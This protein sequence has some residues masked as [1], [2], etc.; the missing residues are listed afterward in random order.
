MTSRMDRLRSSGHWFAIA[1]VFVATCW[2]ST[3]R[4]MGF[5][6][7]P[8]EYN[9]L[10]Q[11]RT[12]LHGRLLNPAILLRE[13]FYF[14]DTVS[15]SAGTYSK[16]PP[17][18]SLLVTLA[19]SVKGYPLVNPLLATLLTWLT[20]RLAVAIAS[21]TIALVA[22][23]LLGSSSFLLIH[24]A[25]GFG[26]V[27][28][29]VCTVHALWMAIEYARHGRRATA[30]AFAFSWAVLFTVRPLNAV[31]LAV[32]LVPFLVLD[33]LR[34]P[35]R[36]GRA[37]E[38]HFWPTIMVGASGPL[39]FLLYNYGTTGNAF[40]FGYNAF[41][42]WDTVRF[43]LPSWSVLQG[44]ATEYG[45]TAIPLAF[46]AMAALY[47]TY[48]RGNG[49]PVGRT[50]VWSLVTVVVT[51]WGVQAV[52]EAPSAI[53]YGPRYVF[54]SH[55]L[56]CILLAAAL[57]DILEP[58]HPAAVAIVTSTLAIVQL[59]AVTSHVRELS[60]TIYQASRI[61]S[62]RQSLARALSPERGLVV[63]TDRAGSLSVNEAAR[64]DP[65]M[66]S[67]PVL[68]GHTRNG[69]PP[70]A[71]PDVGDRRK[72]VWDSAGG[73]PFLWTYDVTAKLQALWVRDGTFEAVGRGPEEG[74]L[75][76]KGSGR[77]GLVRRVLPG[78][79]PRRD[80]LAEFGPCAGDEWQIASWDGRRAL[81]HHPEKSAIVLRTFVAT[82]GFSPAIFRFSADALECEVR[83]HGKVAFSSDVGRGCDVRLQLPYGT[84]AVAVSLFSRNT[85]T[86]IESSLSRGFHAFTQIPD[87]DDVPKDFPTYDEEG[88]AA[89]EPGVF[90]P[91]RASAPR[92]R[93]DVFSYYRDSATV[94][95]DGV[96][97][98]D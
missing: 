53:H 41:D 32:S 88:E 8:E 27:L 92:R 59:N 47:L 48:V 14:T 83:V 44:F 28:S 61:E 18:F 96:G 19:E 42:Q 49:G 51:L 11:G 25:T 65:E 6:L 63:V 57:V 35:T 82:R 45:A 86:N 67:Q 16:F 29:A 64:N 13:E 76:A 98:A 93:I 80:D 7:S 84:S 37:W 2:L 43:G 17:G 90:G 97:S 68:L 30:L 54:E 58:K 24:G 60:R 94:P 77:C 9:L 73:V 50:H 74:W 12:F 5:A 79:R 81:L 62:A 69:L 33:A 36:L 66:R 89:M 95:D 71:M 15:S 56:L 70:W 10:Y 22:S 52:R 55:P 1:A 72:Y 21:P 34:R 91:P 85:E 20:Y 23:I 40:V 31:A 38:V 87:D 4:F 78:L 26:H 46:G 75:L 39:A 3:T